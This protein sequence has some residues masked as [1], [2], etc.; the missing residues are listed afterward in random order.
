M[1]KKI[2]LFLALLIASVMLVCCGKA[3]T[4]ED[5]KSEPQDPIQLQIDQM[6]LVEKIGQMV[7]VGLEGTSMQANAKEMI[8]SY[9][10]GGFI[11]YKN[12]ITDAVQASILL[13]QLK[14]TNY[15][16][17]APLWLS[18]DQEGG[19]VSRL[20][21]S[22]PKIPSAEDIGRKDQPE[23]SYQVGQQLA[24]DIR[25]LGF[26]MNFAPV[27]DINSNPNNPVIGSR[28][29]GTEPQIVIRHGIQTMKGI[30]SKQV[31]PVVKHFP[32]HGDTSVDSHLELPVISKSIDELQAFELLP[33]ADAIK[34]QADAIMIAHLLIPQIDEHSPASLSDKIIRQL[35]RAQLQFDGVVITDDMTMGGITNHYDIGEAAVKS[36]SAGSDIIL[37]GH[38]YN[39]QITVLRALKQSAEDGRL[40]MKAI[41]DSVYRIIRLKLKYNLK[42]SPV[43]TVAP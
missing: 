40:K 5:I 37:V 39:Q 27:L 32:G 18:V 24:E 6:T 3:N 11:L 38:N 20:P 15:S 23:Y 35:L 34:Q 31:V 41:D 43:E 12:N 2:A 25:S 1:N 10:I 9:K 8:E 16:N 28:S 36:V 14:G 30:Q 7:I 22:F 21:E 4:L 42:D 17:I 13:N 33:F 29:F 26:N 19:R